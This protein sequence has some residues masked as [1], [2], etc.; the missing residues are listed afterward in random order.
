MSRLPFTAARRQSGI[1]AVELAIVLIPMLLIVFG[2]TELARMMFTYNEITKAVRQSARYASMRINLDD[3]QTGG[4]GFYKMTSK[5]A[6]QCM[7]VYPNLSGTGPES[8]CSGTPRVPDLSQD[9]VKIRDDQTLT[10]NSQSI[11]Q[12]ITLVSVSV[13]G[14]KYRPIVS[15]VL[16]GVEVPFAPISATLRFE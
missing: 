5:L 10:V 8:G 11:T 14:F 1:A 9:L 13:E 4:D 7:V 15:F 2:I 12:S 3:Q 16:R 6:A